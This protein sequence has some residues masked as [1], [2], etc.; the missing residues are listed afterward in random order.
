MNVSCKITFSVMLFMLIGWGTLT[1][2]SGNSDEE[3]QH[4]VEAF[5]RGMQTADSG[6]VAQIMPP[7]CIM[8]TVAERVDGVEVLIGN[9]DQFVKVIASPPAELEERINGLTIHRD[10]P[11]ATAW[12]EYTFYLDGK[13]HHCGVNNMVL[14]LLE[15][16]WQIIYVSDTR[17]P[18]K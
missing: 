14:A 11:M 8:H 7:S 2:Q 10:G 3:V 1:A 17:R 12:M 13:A 4:A 9:R 5:F 15:G 6:L 16:S 18:C